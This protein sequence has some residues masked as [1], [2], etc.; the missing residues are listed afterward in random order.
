M[1][2]DLEVQLINGGVAPAAAKVISTAI[3]NLTNGKVSLGRSIEDATPTDKMRMITRETRDYIL[4]NLDYASD[5]RFSPSPAFSPRNTRH[6]YEDSQPATA[7]PSIS[8]PATKAG[9]YMQVASATTNSVAQSEVSLRVA[10]RG[11]F[12]AR[13]NPATGEI[14][15]VPLLVEADPKN[16]VEAVVEERPEATVIRLRMLPIPQR[17][18]LHVRL[19]PTSSETESVPFEVEVTGIAP[20]LAGS[21]SAVIEERTASTVLRLQFLQ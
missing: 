15:S 6:P 1:P 16:R 5:R 14:E 3:A 7:N 9:K 4:P 13:L 18:G 19:N 2:S 17:G 20:N 11:G 8:T 21:L 10:N 12:H